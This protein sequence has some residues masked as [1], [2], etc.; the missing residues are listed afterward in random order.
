[1]LEL[2]IGPQHTTQ[3]YKLLQ[4]T[5]AAK[6]KNPGRPTVMT[7]DVLSKLETA[8]LHALTDEEA[9]FY[10]NISPAALYR[11]ETANLEFRERKQALKLQPNIMA[12]VELVQSIKGNIAQARWWAE[13]KMADEF[14]PKTRTEVSGETTTRATMTPEI[15]KVIE[16]ANAK[17][18]EAIAAPH[19]QV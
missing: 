11:Y 17:L 6:K 5:P 7:P 2:Q 19:K 3:A 1:M 9:C 10:A 16:E 8:F 14:A 18:R 12:K 13:H 15:A 4:A